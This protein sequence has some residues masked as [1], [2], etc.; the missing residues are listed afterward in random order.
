MKL[1]KTETERR[2]SSKLGK[3]EIILDAIK[4]LAITSFKIIKIFNGWINSD[5]P[6]YSICKSSLI[7]QTD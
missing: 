5:Y 6:K 2:T 3:I 7:E 4:L 1:A